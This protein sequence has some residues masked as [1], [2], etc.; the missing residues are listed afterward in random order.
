MNIIKIINVNSYYHS[1]FR[2]L[3]EIWVFTNEHKPQ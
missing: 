1:V 3:A 2:E